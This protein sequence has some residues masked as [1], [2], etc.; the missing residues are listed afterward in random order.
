MSS[1]FNP[2]SNENIAK[3]KQQIQQQPQPPR[4]KTFIEQYMENQADSYQKEI[5]NMALQDTYEVEKRDGSKVKLK[6][7]KLTLKQYKDIELDRASLADMRN[8]TGANL[9]ETYERIYLKCA[10]A[11]FGLTPDDVYDIA[12]EDIR[13]V[14]DACNFRTVYGIPTVPSASGTSSKTV[15]ES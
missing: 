9:I 6:R 13:K 11:Y 10:E 15:L 2:G 8:A 12:W 5:A 7:M 4:K 1:E 3:P 14:L